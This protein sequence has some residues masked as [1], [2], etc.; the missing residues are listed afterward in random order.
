[1]TPKKR[2]L[3][4]ETLVRCG[5]VTEAA[6]VAGVSR[7]HLYR[8]RKSDADFAAAWEEAAELG[9][10]ALEDEARRRAHDGVDEPLTSA[11]G[12]IYD[13][14]GKPMMVRKYSDTLLIFL[15]KGARPAKYRER[16]QV[17][18]SGQL[19]ITT[20]AAEAD[21]K[22]MQLMASVTALQPVNGNKEL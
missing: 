11:K 13:A 2:A 18:V 14:D 6:N 22:F 10:D 16:Q 12:L 19:D 4:L 20:L 17:E 15:L 7:Q 21:A 3:F 5:N 9:A 8:M 1:V